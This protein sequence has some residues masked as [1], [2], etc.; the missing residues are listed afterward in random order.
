MSLMPNSAGKALTRKNTTT[1]ASAWTPLA[2]GG[3]PPGN[4]RPGRA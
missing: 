1:T 2:P 3:Q 4:S